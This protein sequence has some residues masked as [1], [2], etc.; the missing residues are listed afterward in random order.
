[1]AALALH[2]EFSD[3]ALAAD[4]WTDNE[5]KEIWQTVEFWLVNVRGGTMEI[6]LDLTCA[7]HDPEEDE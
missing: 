1:M 7:G 5:I 2:E 3:G 6:A 4:D